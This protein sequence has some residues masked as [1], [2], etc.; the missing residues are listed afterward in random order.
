MQ[1]MTY[2]N[3]ADTELVGPSQVTPRDTRKCRRYERIE[4]D[5]TYSRPA[6]VIVPFYAPGSSPPQTAV[7][8]DFGHEAP[9]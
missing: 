1:N 8:H 5:G 2:V 7:A 3:R 9:V 6:H 4:D